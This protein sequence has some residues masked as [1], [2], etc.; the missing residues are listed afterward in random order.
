MYL[1]SDQ[2]MRRKKYLANLFRMLSGQAIAQLDVNWGV[3]YEPFKDHPARD[4]F[5]LTIQVPIVHNSFST[6]FFLHN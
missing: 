4:C 1:G 6:K 2:S 3:D 5:N